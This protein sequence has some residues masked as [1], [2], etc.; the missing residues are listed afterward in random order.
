MSE[1]KRKEAGGESM[2]DCW[3]KGLNGF[4]KSHTSLYCP[5][6]K[7]MCKREDCVFYSA[8]VDGEP[9]EYDANGHVIL[10]SKFGS[11]EYWDEYQK[12]VM[13]HCLVLEILEGLHWLVGRW[14]DNGD[15]DNGLKSLIADMADH[16]WSVDTYE[17]N[18]TRYIVTE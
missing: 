13:H 9:A 7:G 12:S 17:Q 10:I 2:D 14:D 16:K 11:E 5:M 6:V 3:S 1:V 8:E 4:N 18:T 15:N